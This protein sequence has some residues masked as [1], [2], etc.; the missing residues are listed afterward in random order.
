MDMRLRKLSTPEE[1]EHYVDFA[2]EV[3][4]DNPNWVPGDKDHLIK[5]LSGDAGFGPQSEI[6]AFAV[7]HEGRTMAVV[8]AMR[9]E[10]YE[11]HW[12]E[13]LGHLLLFEALPDQDEAVEALIG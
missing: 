5:I 7:E 2:R 12:D 11:R 10:D 4:R 6:Q 13:R 3:Y 9:D 8:A 1:L